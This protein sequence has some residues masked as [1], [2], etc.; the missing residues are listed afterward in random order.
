MLRLSSVCLARLAGAVMFAVAGVPAT[1]P[2]AR[3]QNWNLY[4]S[5][6]SFFV[7]IT[8]EANLN[9]GPPQYMVSLTLNGRTNPFILDT[10]SLGLVADPT[11]YHPGSDPV[12][13]DYATITYSTSG[14]NPVGKLYLTTVQING[15]N[16]QSVTARVPILG[17]SNYGYHQLGIG[18]DR[19]GIMIGPD[20]ATLSPANNTY[21]MNPFL[22][23]V[24][25]PGVSTMQPGYIIGVNGFQNLGLGPG[26]LLGLNGQNTAG[27][28]FQQLASNGGLPSYCSVAGMGCPLQWSAQNGSISIT[29][30]GQTYNLG[31][32][33]QLPD[34]GISYMIVNAP[35]NA[36][37]VGTGNC[38]DGSGTPHNC[39]QS[40]TVSVYLPGQTQPAYTFTLGDGSN[41]STPFGV[42]VKQGV[43]P[44]NLGRTFFDNLNYLYDP[45]N[46]FVGFQ[47]AGTAGTTA[48][49]IPMLA[50][51]G[52]LTLPNGFLSSFTTFL[53]GNLTLQQTGSGTL[54][55]P[56]LGPGGLALQS[57]N[58]TL[59]GSNSYAGGTAV[60]GGMLTIGSSGSITGEVTV[61]GGSLIN[62][63]RIDGNGLV[64]VNVGGSF[65]NN[66]TVNTPSQ[67]Q[68]NQ[69][70]FTNNSAFNGSLA[71]TGTA[72]NNGTIDGSVINGT[73]GTFENAGTI[74]GSVSN[75][76]A[77][78]GNGTIG[79][80]FSNMGNLSGTGTI[81]G[82]LS[83]S[84]MLAPGNS[85]GT[86]TVAGNFTQA[87]SGIYSVEV[88]GAGQS[89]LISVG[90]TASL[91]GAVSVYAQPGTTFAPSTTYRILSAAGGVSGTFASVNELYPFLLSSLSYDT[92]NA[93]LTLD[94]GGFA[95]VAATPMQ[96]AV[97]AV[98]DANVTNASGDFATV[99]GALAFSTTS[100]A[101]AQAALQ[102]LSGNNY[103][104]FSSVMVQG[105]QLFMNN[106]AGQ[107]GGGSG[108]D[109]SVGRVAL[110][111]ACDVACDTAAPALWSAWGGALGGLGTIGASQ[112]TG[113]VTYNVGGFAAGL[114][115]LV[116]PTTR[117]GVTTGY[118]TGTQW[119]SGF[120]GQGRTDTFNV[121]LYGNYA[122]G[123]VYADALAGYAYSWNQMWRP[124]SLPGLQPR[125]ALGQT[126]ANQWYGQL[127][128][129]WRFDIG[130]AANAFVTPFARLQGYT[131]TQ[132]GFTETGA[133]SLNLTVA[134]QTTNSLRSVIG[135]QLGGSLDLGWRERLALQL[136]LGWSHEYADV[137]RPVS[138]TLAG[139]PGMPFT[140]YGISPQRDGAVVGFAANT[141]LADAT[142]LYLRYEATVAGQD[143]AHALTAGVRMIW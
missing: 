65:V 86:L 122:Q 78:T 36:V 1:S 19:G 126:G 58:V 67:W 63:G 106:F 77:F 103:A 15:A 69:G 132:N 88:G 4:G 9:G 64:T 21:N 14:A 98:L 8:T 20:S 16:G 136:R 17:S 34:S 57:G 43:P 32:A 33:S 62:N 85:I 30:G 53:M 25:G 74:T 116:T 49:I 27:F 111:E 104:G 6:S 5:G 101:Q 26:V 18:F 81:G 109:G 134:Q 87:A 138:A 31:S 44:S 37:P 13:A 90:G 91:G 23:L 96:A 40:G 94:I 55:G 56:I 38:S 119:V 139:A 107:T 95:S 130:T 68:L 24:S 143:S 46:G 133:Q 118:S 73:T 82:A 12:L 45:I 41:P 79:G 70:T 61:N 35:G 89:D 102:Q 42:Q 117:M 51:Q 121:G 100:T 7:P 52:S 114:D 83:S 75:M 142:N 141:A 60:N 105:A 76:G 28:A 54:S 3:A 2:T 72:A 84:G 48:T 39:L 93:Y 115:R 108:N 11:H 140:T 71:N 10:G 80:N 124:I 22:A 97:G 127:E 47:A 131:G 125:T 129:G 99:L 113:G 59:G 66:G 128:A 50:L 92:N 110:A 135:A 112:P 120:A 29:T 123:P 137:S